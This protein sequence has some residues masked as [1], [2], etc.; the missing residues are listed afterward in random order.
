LARGGAP[1]LL[2][3]EEAAIRNARVWAAWL[4]DSLVGP[5]VDLDEASHCAHMALFDVMAAI[6]ARDAK[7]GGAK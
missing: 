2:F 4:T 5:E 6:E 7:K 3:S 1:L